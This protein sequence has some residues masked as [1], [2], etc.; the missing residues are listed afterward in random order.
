M[1][2]ALASIGAAGAAGTVFY[3][4]VQ[5][6]LQVQITAVLSEAANTPEHN[7]RYLAAKKCQ[8]SGD[9]YLPKLC[10]AV[11]QQLPASYST[12]TGVLDQ[13]VENAMS[14]IFNN[15]AYSICTL[16]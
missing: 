1:A 2:L 5:G 4:Q 3:Q 13:D 6:A 14:A 16:S 11:A 9:S 7:V 15:F 12:L 8:I 10:V